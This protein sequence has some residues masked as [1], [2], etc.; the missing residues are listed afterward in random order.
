MSM[1]KQ[2]RNTR[3]EMGTTEYYKSKKLKR[4]VVMIPMGTW[5]AAKDI[6]LDNDENFTEF[7]KRA[8]QSEVDRQVKIKDKADREKK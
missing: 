4:T 8:L 7:L 1:Q 5:R 2:E 6:A 3:K